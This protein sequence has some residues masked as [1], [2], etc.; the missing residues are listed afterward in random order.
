MQY[1][2]IKDEK[3]YKEVMDIFFDSIRTPTQ[4]FF[5]PQFIKL[6]KRLELESIVAS[7]LGSLAIPKL[8][9]D[10]VEDIVDIHFGNET[11]VEDGKILIRGLNPFEKADVVRYHLFEL[12]Y[13]SIF[14]II[15]NFAMN[16]C[17]VIINKDDSIKNKSTILK[18]LSF[19]GFVEC[20]KFLDNNIDLKSEELLK[21]VNEEIKTMQF[22][23]NCLVHNLGIIEKY[24]YRKMGYSKSQIGNKVMIDFE[25]IMKSQFIAIKTGRLIDIKVIELL[26]KEYWKED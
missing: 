15:E 17:S 10:K 19:S 3:R 4:N 21:S 8:I 23:R 26:G 25:A 24:N 1:P 18:D 13:I 22:R 2:V 7:T 12:T 6:E 9:G 11:K 20:M 16:I 14:S 5:T